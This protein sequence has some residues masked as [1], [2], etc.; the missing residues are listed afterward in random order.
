MSCSLQSICPYPL[1]SPRTRGTP[2]VLISLSLAPIFCCSTFFSLHSHS[3]LSPHSSHPFLL[4]P[5]LD[6][7]ILS[8][9]FSQLSLLPSLVPLETQTHRLGVLERARAR[10]RERE[11]KRERESTIPPLSVWPLERHAFA[12]TAGLRHPS[13]HPNHL[14][15]PSRRRARER[16]EEGIGGMG[17]GRAARN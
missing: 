3:S 10:T 8:P 15:A 12:D 5:T 16:D 4:S 17:E 11:R 1:I 7:S 13:V 14:A 9:V 2:Q 6:C